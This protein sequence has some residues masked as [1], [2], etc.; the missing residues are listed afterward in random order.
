MYHFIYFLH[1]RLI[2]IVKYCNFFLQYFSGIHWH[3]FSGRCTTVYITFACRYEKTSF[4]FSQNSTKALKSGKL[5]FLSWNPNFCFIYGWWAAFCIRQA[6]RDRF[7]QAVEILFL[8]EFE[9]EFFFETKFLFQIF[10][11]HVPL[12]DLIR[13]P[14]T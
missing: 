8:V 11:F 14:R 4:F 9:V 5:W 6:I 12:H 2:I 3:I 10:S 13:D 1:L 7:S